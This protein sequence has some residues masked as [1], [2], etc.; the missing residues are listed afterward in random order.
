MMDYIYIYFFFQ[1]LQDLR[2]ELK[3]Q[4]SGLY[5]HNTKISEQV[6]DLKIQNEK[7]ENFYLFIYL[8]FFLSS[9]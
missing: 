1:L 8:F 7:Y 2:S 6:D 5:E 4:Q 3:R 9:N